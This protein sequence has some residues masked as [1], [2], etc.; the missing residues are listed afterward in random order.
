MSPEKDHQVKV[1]WEEIRDTTILKSSAF[2]HLM[3]DIKNPD[4]YTP[5][6]EVWEGF[7]KE[8]EIIYDAAHKTL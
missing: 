2:S 6:G 7:K 5:W 4:K 3:R 8:L 1:F